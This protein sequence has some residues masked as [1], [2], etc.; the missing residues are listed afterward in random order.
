MFVKPID[1]VDFKMLSQSVQAWYRYYDRKPD[2]ETS[3]VLCSAAIMLFNGGHQLRDEV[4]AILIARFPAERF[5]CENLI[6]R[7]HVH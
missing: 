5:S 4:A 7:R 6:S 1:D 2:P 3:Q